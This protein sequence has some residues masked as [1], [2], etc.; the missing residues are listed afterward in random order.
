MYRRSSARLYQLVAPQIADGFQTCSQSSAGASRAV[1]DAAHVLWQSQL[2]AVCNSWLQQ[3]GARS[4][5][6]W[7]LKAPLG[8]GNGVCRHH[9]QQR[10]GCKPCSSLLSLTMHVVCWLARPRG[11]SS[12]AGLILRVVFCRSSAAAC[13]LGGAIQ[14]GAVRGVAATE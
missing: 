10:V 3:L 13:S 6:T 5:R 14:A 12:G 4:L 1:A 9:P 2:Q 7:S 8:L 11:I